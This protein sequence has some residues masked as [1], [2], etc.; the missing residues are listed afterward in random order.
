MA[1]ENDKLLVNTCVNYLKMLKTEQSEEIQINYWQNIQKQIVMKNHFNLQS[2]VIITILFQEI[3]IKH[4]MI[5]QSKHLLFNINNF[6]M[7]L[8]EDKFK[9]LFFNLL[10]DVL[11]SEYDKYKPYF[12]SYLYEITFRLFFTSSSSCDNVSPQTNEAMLTFY[13]TAIENDFSP[14]ENQLNKYIH[15]SKDNVLQ[16]Y[17]N[18]PVYMKFFIKFISK[19]LSKR[20]YAKVSQLLKQLV[21]DTKYK[22]F[23]MMLIKEINDVAFMAFSKKHLNAFDEFMFMNSIVLSLINNVSDSNSKLNEDI[24]D[25]YLVNLLLVIIEHNYFNI[26]IIN[27]M[28]N[29]HHNNK[30]N[31]FNK[32]IYISV[33]YLSKYVF[34]KEHVEFYIQHV[35]TKIDDPL[36]AVLIYNSFTRRNLLSHVRDD[37]LKQINIKPFTIK[38]TNN[39]VNTATTNVNEHKA[40]PTYG[41]I[42][43]NKTNKHKLMYLSLFLVNE[44][45]FSINSLTHVIELNPTTLVAHMQE[46]IKFHIDNKINPKY[47]VTLYCDFFD[48]L[49][50]SVVTSHEQFPVYLIQHLLLMINQTDN[51]FKYN[52]IYPYLIYITRSFLIPQYDLFFNAETNSNMILNEVISFFIATYTRNENISNFLFKLLIALF[53]ETK[54]SNKQYKIFA[55]DKLVSL[56]LHANNG[57]INEYLFKFLRDL[58]SAQDTTNYGYFAFYEYARQYT[59]ALNDSI[60]H[61]LAELYDKETNSNN[62]NGKLSQRYLF[63]VCCLYWVYAKDPLDTFQKLFDN[64]FIKDYYTQLLK[65]ILSSISK[66]VVLD[67]YDNTAM[68]LN[69]TEYNNYIY[70]IINNVNTVDNDMF[71]LCL[72]KYLG[73][74]ITTYIQ[75][76]CAKVEEMNKQEDDTQKQLNAFLSKESTIN[77][78]IIILYNE[79][80]T[81]VQNHKKNYI[82]FFINELLNNATVINHYM[83]C[84]SND[85][86]NVELKEKGIPFSELQRYKRNH[87]KNKVSNIFKYI[88]EMN[89]LN[90]LLLN[91]FIIE[92]INVE[93]IQILNNNPKLKEMNAIEKKVVIVKTIYKNTI[94]NNTSI[95][96]LS[97]SSSENVSM[98]HKEFQTYQQECFFSTKLFT[99]IFDYVYL[100]ET[101]NIHRML[102]DCKFFSGKFKD[103]SNMFNVDVLLIQFYD[104]V[105]MHSQYKEYLYYFILEY[106]NS[107]FNES[108]HLFMLKVLS[109]TK[110]FNT[111]YSHNETLYKIITELFANL[112]LYNSYEEESLTLIKQIIQNIRTVNTNEQQ[113]QQQTCNQLYNELITKMNALITESQTKQNLKL[114]PKFKETLLTFIN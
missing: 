6:C 43:Y 17:V 89:S 9:Q 44:H 65:Q 32:L 113:Q 48:I 88:S 81:I 4:K 31:K 80:D 45:V 58:I 108:I 76:Y 99:Y 71:Y 54:I 1:T 95:T 19:A 64:L 24:L 36:Y 73:R 27:M 51:E 84:H 72:L 22:E 23:Y 53:K 5:I 21:N 55:L 75:I 3:Y 98:K 112:I 8:N 66:D 83:I 11:N 62:N 25:S 28:L 94:R 91:N 74:L 68:L 101:K 20:K 12:V 35:I 10:F 70:S 86:A 39:T 96:S 42:E 104:L 105:K 87:I 56:T 40:F 37:I 49:I 47:I 90:A 52:S 102:I 7:T 69:K 14:F 110:T 46:I 38:Y 57:K 107:P 30:Y 26:D 93:R 85:K 61:Y 60:R 34:L 97:S 109:N 2:D 29:I 106:L 82:C 33:Y 100:Y 78:H 50:S 15:F 111:I 41:Q 114:K 59:G 103:L 79:I 92:I 16:M 67:T 18:K 63:I 13:N 77:Q